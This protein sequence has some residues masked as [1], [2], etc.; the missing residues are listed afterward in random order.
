M[1]NYDAKELLKKYKEGNCTPQELAIIES[2]YL[3]DSEKDSM[4]DLQPESFA[5]A[6][7]MIWS[8]LPVHETVKSQTRLSW[9]GLPV[10]YS[11]IA[12]AAIITLCVSYSLYFFSGRTKK[13]ETT[14]KN[15]AD[16]RPGGHKA[17]LTMGDGKSIALNDM[18]NGM[19]TEEAGTNIIKPADGQLVYHAANASQKSIEYHLLT[20]PRGG[21]YTLTLADGTKV[22]LN[23]E[24]SLRYP[25]EFVGEERIVELTGEGYFEVA[26]RNNQPFKVVTQ[27]QTIEVLGTHFNVNT[28]CDEGRIVTSLLEGSVQLH[29][30]EGTSQRLAPG[31][32]ASLY[33]GGAF[34]VAKANV[35]EAVDWTT[36]EFIFTKESLT[37]IMNKISRW[38]DVDVSC[39]ADLAKLTFTG[40]ISRTKNIHQVLEIMRTTELVNF[41]IEGRRITVTR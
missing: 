33:R 41:K 32:Q 35:D 31:E 14:A 1:N 12:A 24:S 16:I 36:N 21:Y 13:Q 37:S 3:H 6:K 20:I 18:Q 40:H 26:H 23:A 25:N 2:W 38:Y 11:R 5:N 17:I 27:Q 28:Y 7:E 9:F 15:S 30:P 39:P 10:H 8:N 22:W 4:P 29:T 34:R 19:L